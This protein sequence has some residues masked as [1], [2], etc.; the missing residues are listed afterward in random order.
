MR[1]LAQNQLSPLTA[2]DAMEE[3]SKLVYGKYRDQARDLGIFSVIVSLESRDRCT[4]AACMYV[5][6]Y[7]YI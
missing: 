6:V 4:Q 1:D 3:T 5:N 7:I 2:L